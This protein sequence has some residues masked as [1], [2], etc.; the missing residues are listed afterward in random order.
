MERI[1]SSQEITWFLD[2]ERTGQLDLEPPYQR[3]SVWTAMDRKYFLDTIFRNYPCP[4]VFIHKEVSDSGKTTYHVVDGKQRLQTIMMFNN[5]EIGLD[6]RFG[7]VTF[8][9]K[10]F[11]D[12]S[13]DQKRLFWNY[14]IMVDFISS[15]DTVSI[16]EVFDRLNRNSKHLNPQELRHAKYNGWF[17]TEVE[18]EA[19]NKFWE[20]VRISTKASS[21]RMQ[22]VQFISELLMMLLEK[23]VV[24]FDQD[25]ITEIYAA[26]DSVPDIDFEEDF[27]ISEKERIKRYVEQMVNDDKEMIKWIKTR[28]NFYAL[29]SLVALSGDDLP[30]PI[31]LARKYKTFMKKVDVAAEA[32]PQ[33]I[34]KL[35]FTYYSNSRGPNTDPAQRIERLDSLKEALLSNENNR[36]DS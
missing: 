13:R 23:K 10:K 2:L 11:K 5:N 32:D 36:L 34:E 17:I 31:E 18:K 22:D 19:E 12:L 35:V 27:Y 6:R 25:H 3:K 15:T 28:N 4:T 29:W 21:K 7:D 20:R 26:Y 1:P 24:G 16:N 30:D 9:G 33:N 14:T 8:A